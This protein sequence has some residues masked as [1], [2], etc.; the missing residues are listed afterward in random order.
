[1]VFLT[2]SKPFRSHVSCAKCQKKLAHGICATAITDIELHRPNKTKFVFEQIRQST[3]KIYVIRFECGYTT[4]MILCLPWRLAQFYNTRNI[5]IDVR[6]NWK[7]AAPQ[8]RLH[9]NKCVI[10][11]F[12]AADQPHANHFHQYNSIFALGCC[13]FFFVILTKLDK[14]NCT[15]RDAWQECIWCSNVFLRHMK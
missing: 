2:L 15:K 8:I 5:A 4:L 11:H 3:T 10:N 9:Q 1:M 12:C 14:E 7:Y 6:W 13:C